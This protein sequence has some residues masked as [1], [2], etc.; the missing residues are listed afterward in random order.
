VFKGRFVGKGN[1][2]SVGAG[3]EEGSRR[4][5]GARGKAEAEL[6]AAVHIFDTL[7]EE[8]WESSYQWE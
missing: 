4:D 3:I 7:Q 1:D 8:G 6:G 5:T 2:G